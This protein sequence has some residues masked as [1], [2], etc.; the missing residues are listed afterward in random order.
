[1]LPVQELCLYPLELWGK[2]VI[3]LSH[4]ASKI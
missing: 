2:L 4:L 3:L 1:M